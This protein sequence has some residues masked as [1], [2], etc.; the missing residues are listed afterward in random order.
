MSSEPWVWHSG[1]KTPSLHLRLSTGEATSSSNRCPAS[2]AVTRLP[3]SLQRLVKEAL[4]P[5]S[6][7]AKRPLVLEGL[8][9]WETRR[10]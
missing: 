4:S 7:T 5:Q 6:A 8:Q 1:L 3:K 2:G 9:R 10:S